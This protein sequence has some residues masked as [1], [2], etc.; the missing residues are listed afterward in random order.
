MRGTNEL[1]ILLVA[2]CGILQMYLIHV[3]GTPSILLLTDSVIVVAFFG[4]VIRYRG[5]RRKPDEILMWRIG[6]VILLL[7]NIPFFVV[8]WLSSPEVLLTLSAGF[9]ITMVNFEEL[10]WFLV[11]KYKESRLSNPIE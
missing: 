8:I 11:F 9:L 4:G 1:L 5:T 2:S 3:S 6:V 7:C 10:G